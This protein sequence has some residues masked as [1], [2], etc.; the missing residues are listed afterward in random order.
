VT[1]DYVSRALPAVL[2]LG[3]NDTCGGYFETLH[4]DEQRPQVSVGLRALD[5]A[6]QKSSPVAIAVDLR[7]PIVPWRHVG[8]APW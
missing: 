7:H 2:V 6:G 5:M 3:E 4:L 1:D 8:S